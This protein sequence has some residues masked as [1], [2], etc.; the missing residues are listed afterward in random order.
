[1]SGLFER[2]YRVV[3]IKPADVLIISNVGEV[4]S[5]DQR[6]IDSLRDDLGCT[7][8]YFFAGDINYDLLRQEA[9]DE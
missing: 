3:V 7:S 8:V 5:F 1:V 9:P 2:D 6:A 4:A